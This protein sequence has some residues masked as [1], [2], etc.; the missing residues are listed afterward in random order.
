MKVKA[1]IVDITEWSRDEQAI[2]GDASHE[3]DAAVLRLVA[4]EVQ[5]KLEDCT[6]DPLG[7]PFTRE[8]DVLPC[9]EEN[10][11]DMIRRTLLDMYVET[12]Y[13]FAYVKPT[14]CEVEWED[15]TK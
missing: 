6:H 15:T 13:R 3:G 10:A 2:A 1:T 4:D 9:Q 5:E 8:I 14:D 7:I 12:H 11:D